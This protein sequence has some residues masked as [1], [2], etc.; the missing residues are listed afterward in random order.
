MDLES[1]M[2]MIVSQSKGPSTRE[3]NKRDDTIR[4][5]IQRKSDWSRGG[6]GGN[7]GF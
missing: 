5:Y 1:W 7:N 2:N 4:E 6:V 3:R